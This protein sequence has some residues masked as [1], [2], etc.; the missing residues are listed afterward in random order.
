[1]ADATAQKDNRMYIYHEENGKIVMD[2]ADHTDHMEQN[3]LGGK[4]RD[5]KFVAATYLPLTD[6][7][8]ARFAAQFKMPF[9]ETPRPALKPLYHQARWLKGYTKSILLR[10]Q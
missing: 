7:E 2:R 8:K 1:M 9:D 3:G 4:P 5:Y 6:A 10:L